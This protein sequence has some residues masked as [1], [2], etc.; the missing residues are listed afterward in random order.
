L[1]TFADSQERF[2]PP[3]VSKPPDT[4]KLAPA[5]ELKSHNIFAPL[6]CG[7]FPHYSVKVLN[8]LVVKFAALTG[9]TKDIWD[10]AL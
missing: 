1:P 3:K 6:M 7:G 10:F 8:N 9:I 5:A 2:Q 4:G